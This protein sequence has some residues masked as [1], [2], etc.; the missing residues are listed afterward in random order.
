MRG[1][2]G[3][4][5]N[6]HLNTCHANKSAAKRLKRE[7]YF[8]LD[9]RLLASDVTLALNK[10]SLLRGR[11]CPGLGRRPSKI[12]SELNPTPQQRRRT[13]LSMPSLS[14]PTS[15]LQKQERLQGAEPCEDRGK[16]LSLSLSFPSLSCFSPP[17]SLLPSL[18]SL[19]SSP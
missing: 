4:W 3:R 12:S 10:T 8:S 13:G 17:P 2:A 18:L 11:A 15:A 1:Y 9:F 6:R 16:S 7:T 19:V 5:L 14:P